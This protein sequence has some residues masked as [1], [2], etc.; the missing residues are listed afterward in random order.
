MVKITR[1]TPIIFLRTAWMNFYEGV[2]EFDIPK[3]GGAYVDKNKD[4]GEVYNF[5]KI[6]GKY[7]GFAGIQKGRKINLKNLGIKGE[8][9]EIENVLVVFFATNP[10]T[11]GKY[12]VG[13]Y[14]NAI[15]YSSPDKQSIRGR[16]NWK[17]YLA[18]C[19]TE[20]G[21]LIDP[22]KRTFEV[23]GPG[24]SNIWYPAKSKSDSELKALY[25]YL[26][27]PDVGIRNKKKNIT[28]GGGWQPDPELRKKI[29]WSAMTSVRSYF[30]SR[31]FYVTDVHKDNRGWDLEAENGT[32]KLFLE[33]KGTQ[34]AFA[35][36]R[37]TPNEYKQMKEKKSNY[38][39][40]VVS[41]ALDDKRRKNIIFYHNGKDWIDQ[42][43]QKL[44]FR[45]EVFATVSPQ[46]TEY[47]L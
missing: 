3:N 16:G 2:T 9:T 41:H 7:Y 46:S 24:Q 4:G 18:V 38:R 6:N 39:L 32:K 17:N 37:I 47:T 29:E 21:R 43:E 35:G 12:I 42:N 8:S 26:N 19:E 33:V 27:K 40:C 34:T 45:E 13:W 22:D 23:K 44:V 36:V 1:S 31:G 28:K 11:S 15:L 25:R 30:E 20:D 10:I 14:K 5:K